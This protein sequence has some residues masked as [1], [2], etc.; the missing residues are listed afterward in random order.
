MRK[1]I[2]DL[3]TGIKLAPEE[4]FGSLM[5]DLTRK[6]ENNQVREWRRERANA[7]FEY[8]HSLRISEHTRQ[9]RTAT[10]VVALM[11]AANFVITWYHAGHR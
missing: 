8:I 7:I 10:W 6:P 9:M 5:E 2:E 11:T 4:D 3:I 1:K